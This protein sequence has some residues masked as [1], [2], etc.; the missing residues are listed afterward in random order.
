MPILVLQLVAGATEILNWVKMNKLTTALIASSMLLTTSPYAAEQDEDQQEQQ[1]SNSSSSYQGEAYHYQDLRDRNTDIEVAYAD[2]DYGNSVSILGNLGLME[3]RLSLGIGYSS[4]SGDNDH[5]DYDHYYFDAQFNLT[6]N[7]ILGAAYYDDAEAFKVNF[8]YVADANFGVWDVGAY[9]FDG[10][11]GMR[12]GALIP[13]SSAWYYRG[14]IDWRDFD[15][16][17]FTNR[18]GAVF[19]AFDVGVEYVLQDNNNDHW[20]LSASMH[21]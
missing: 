5:F 1:N 6:N 21:F 4:F 16:L 18:V 14:D 19:G 10:D 17:T 15:Y 13:I 3:N 9:V 12:A 8:D 7:M 20:K 2:Y 11:I